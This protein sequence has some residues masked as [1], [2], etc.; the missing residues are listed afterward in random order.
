MKRILIFILLVLASM[1]LQ[2]QQPRVFKSLTVGN[3][4]VYVY[5]SIM[6]TFPPKDTTYRYY[7]DVVRDT[8]INGK[9]YAVV[10]SSFDNSIRF[11]RSDENNLYVWQNNQEILLHS[12]NFQQ[13][14]S[15]RFS[16]LGFN[17][18]LQQA[19]AVVRPEKSTNPQT[20]NDR[21][22]YSMNYHWNNLSSDDALVSYAQLRGLIQLDYYSN[23]L[24][25]GPKLEVTRLFQGGVID[26][27][28][29][30]DT[31]STR[32]AIVGVN[33]EEIPIGR[34]IATL[35]QPNPFTESV[36]FSYAL[37]A[38]AQNVELRIYSASGTTLGVLRH[39]AQSTGKHTIDWNGKAADGT[40]VPSGTYFVALYV[41]GRKQSETK[42]IKMK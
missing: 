2:A 20:G 41:D 3:R 10:F 4:F 6:R 29:V 23:S 31:T 36:D 25:S 19:F 8:T 15:V 1:P 28:V 37:P 22:V 11:E 24:R 5:Y 9:K 21:L 30:Q 39:G 7:E 17:S 18:N 35:S 14:D 26:G 42:V 33:G 38:A 13:G 32:R 16:F 12:L 27:V 34:S 40:D